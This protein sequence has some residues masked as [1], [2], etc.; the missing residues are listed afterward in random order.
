MLCHRVPP[1]LG[2]S[3]LWHSVGEVRIVSSLSAWPSALLCQTHIQVM[4][5]VG[6]KVTF[7][8][9][10][11]GQRHGHTMTNL[12]F[13]VFNKQNIWLF[14]FLWEG[15]L[16]LLARV[17]FSPVYF[18]IQLEFLLRLVINILC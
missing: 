2:A 3:G 1:G 15:C 17:K 11:M 13:V 4:A 8:Y 6:N 14:T 16:V 5:L 12:S 10:E 7:H 9:N 18:F